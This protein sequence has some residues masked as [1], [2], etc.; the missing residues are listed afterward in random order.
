[1]HRW[2]RSIDFSFESNPVQT[3]IALAILIPR[4]M[5]SNFEILEALSRQAEIV[6]PM[7]YTDKPAI[8]Q[9]VVAISTVICGV[10]ARRLLSSVTIT[11]TSNAK[12]AIQ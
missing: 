6:A 7:P 5:Q 11:K 3:S 2:V 8:M 1:M 12:N 10:D 9:E 4:L